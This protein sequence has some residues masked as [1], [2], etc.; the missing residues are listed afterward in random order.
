M[1]GFLIYR[2]NGEKIDCFGRGYF[3]EPRKDERYCI[4]KLILLLIVRKIAAFYIFDVL[5]ESTTHA[6]VEV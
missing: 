6:F 5:L 1:N 4:C 2:M 3:Q